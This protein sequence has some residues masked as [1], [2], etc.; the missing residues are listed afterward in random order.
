MH[1]QP[2]NAIFVLTNVEQS[3]L[4]IFKITLH[5]ELSAFR[6]QYHSFWEAKED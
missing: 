1:L 5:S 6:D 3:G 2:E 4:N